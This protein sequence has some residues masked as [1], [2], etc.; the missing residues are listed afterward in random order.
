[1]ARTSFVNIPTASE[2]VDGCG[3]GREVVGN[4]DTRR[5]CVHIGECECAKVV[6]VWSGRSVKLSK[7]QLWSGC[8]GSVWRVC[9]AEGQGSDRRAL[10]MLNG[11]G[12]IGGA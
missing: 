6:D 12:T 9:G 4:V 10:G 2:G 7:L 3:E 11:R 1:M 5:T 8:G